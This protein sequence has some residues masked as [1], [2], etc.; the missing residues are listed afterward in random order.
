MGLVK[1]SADN[2]SEHADD[3]DVSSKPAGAAFP[4]HI[5]SKLVDTLCSTQADYVRI[6][7]PYTPIAPSLPSL[8]QPFHVIPIRND[9]FT[10]PVPS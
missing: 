2:D 3:D 6:C 7:V 1:G 9:Y 5:L 4:H 8:T 10:I